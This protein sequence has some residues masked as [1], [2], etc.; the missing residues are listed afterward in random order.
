VVRRRPVPV[1]WRD[2]HHS[3]WVR[4]RY[5]SSVPQQGIRTYRA[6][7]V[8]SC[9]A[10]FGSRADRHNM[11]RAD[12]IEAWKDHVEDAYYEQESAQ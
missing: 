12:V 4:S 1:W 11:E 7:G 9:G 5:H 10:K 2:Q 3:L 6:G 8:C